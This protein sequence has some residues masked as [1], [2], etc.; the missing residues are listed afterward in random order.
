MSKD[1]SS[2]YYQKSKEKL[3]KRTHER[4]ENLLGEEKEKL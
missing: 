1:S 3:S 2:E 4:Y